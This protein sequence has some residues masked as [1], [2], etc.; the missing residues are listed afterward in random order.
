MRWGWLT[1]LAACAVLPA[2]APDPSGYYGNTQPAYDG[3]TQPG[4]VSPGYVQP[5]YV[6]PDGGPVYVQP[7]GY[8]GPV[9]PGFVPGPG[10]GYGREREFH[11]EFR[12]RDIRERQFR[13]DQDRYNRERFER[14]RIN[15]QRRPEPPRPEPPRQQFRPPTQTPPLPGGIFPGV[16]RPMPQP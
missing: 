10:Y 11:R 16:P 6:V 8:S 15:E 14:D 2:C 5:G 9:G 7:Y 12:D 4:Y 13:G 3:Y 1:G